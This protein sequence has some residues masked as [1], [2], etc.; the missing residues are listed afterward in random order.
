MGKR[1]IWAGILA[2]AL[3]VPGAA[4][5][6]TPAQLLARYQPVTYFSAAEK[7]RPTTVETFVADATLEQPDIYG[8]WVVADEDPKAAG[9]PV[10]GRWR[11]NQDTCSPAATLGGLGCYA[12]AWAAQDAPQVVYG[13]AVVTRRVAVLQY[14]S[15]YYENLYSYANPPSDFIW[16][17]HEA[18]WE[19]VSTVLRRARGDRPFRPAF[20]AYS[21]HCTGERRPWGRVPRWRRT[22]PVVRVALGSHANYFGAGRHPIAVECIPPQAVALLRQNNLALPVDYTDNGAAAGPAGLGA[23]VTAIRR[24]T[25]ST[26]RWIR[27][28]GTWGELQYFHAPAPVGTVALGASPVG[29]ARQPAWRRPLATLAT[30]PLR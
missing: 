1:W 29:P 25:G 9:L 4:Q 22:H 7:F 16:Q 20:V 5:A 10:S 12:D 2:V 19:V 18:D 6:A 24:V 8:T 27:F 13:R 17:A 21:Q 30:W 3:A 15:F 28:P 11:L 14:W 26:P 23:E